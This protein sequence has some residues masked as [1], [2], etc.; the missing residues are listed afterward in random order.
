MRR[1]NGN[2]KSL[3]YGDVVLP[4]PSGY[5]YI[6]TI[7]P[8]DSIRLGR[9]QKGEIPINEALPNH[10]RF[11]QMLIVEYMRTVTV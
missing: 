5:K 7:M 3:Q 9:W 8:S 1:F 10:D 4:S 6:V 2:Y 11:D